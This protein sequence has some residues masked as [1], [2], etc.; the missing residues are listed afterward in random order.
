MQVLT[1]L[2]IPDSSTF[3]CLFDIANVI[4]EGGWGLMPRLAPH[5]PTRS[6]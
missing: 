4:N 6:G 2:V 3:C 1:W 5:S